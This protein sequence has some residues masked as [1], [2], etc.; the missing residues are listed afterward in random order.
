MPLIQ[1]PDELVSEKK[2]DHKPP[3]CCL[4][5]R[6]QQSCSFQISGPI[7]DGRGLEWLVLL[8]AGLSNEHNGWMIL[9]QTN[10]ENVAKQ[11]EYI[12]KNDMMTWLMSCRDWVWL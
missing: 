7:T 9:D 12:S 4:A 1:L 2:I 11:R 5:D 10:L 6:I 3:T 8:H